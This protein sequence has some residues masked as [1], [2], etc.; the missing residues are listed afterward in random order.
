MKYN[1]FSLWK[2]WACESQYESNIWK[3][4]LIKLVVVKIFYIVIF[5]NELYKSLRVDIVNI[6]VRWNKWRHNIL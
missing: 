1:N 6:D 2:C 3:I 5:T 4:N